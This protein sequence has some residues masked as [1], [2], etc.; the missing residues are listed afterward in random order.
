MVT[1]Q[2]RGLANDYFL[3]TCACYQ[4]DTIKVLYK[5]VCSRHVNY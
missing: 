1:C 5:F 2:S 4:T 3:F